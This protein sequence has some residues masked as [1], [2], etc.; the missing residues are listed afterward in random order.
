MKPKLLIVELWGLGDLVIATPFIRAAAEKFD[1]TVL[2]KPYANDLQKVFWPGVTVIPF[3]APWTAFKHKYRL[4]KWPWRELFQVRR[5]IGWNQ[6]D[7]GLSARWDPRDHLLLLLAGVRERFGFPRIGSQLSLTSPVIKAGA[8][9]HRYRAWQILANA[10]GLTLP[11]KS[12][13]PTRSPGSPGEILIHTGAGQSVRV[14]PL[15]RYKR[16]V[17]RLRRCGFAVQVACDPNQIR[18]WRLM[19]ETAALVPHDVPELLHS[20]DR[21]GIFIGND[22]GPGHLAALQ[23]VP[24][25]TLF[26]PQLPQCFAPLHEHAEWIEG[27]ACPHKPCSDYCRYAL[28]HCLWDLSEETVWAR[29]IA[30]VKKHEVMLSTV[31]NSSFSKDEK[32]I[33]RV[34]DSK[35]FI[36]VFNRYL[37]SGGE[38][39]SVARI[40]THLEEAGH[41]VVRFWR[42]SE[43]WEGPESPSALRRAIQLM[44]N[45]AVL[46][47]LREIHQRV[48][49]DAWILHNVIPVISLSIYHLALEL[50]VPIIRWGHNYRP[51]SPSGTMRLRGT[52]LLPDD[53]WLAWKEALAGTWHGRLATAWLALG[54]AWLRFRGDFE[55]VK[56]WIVLSSDMQRTYALAGA[57]RDR[58]YCLSHSWDIRPLIEPGADDGYF[59]FMG[60]MVE[61]KGVKFLLELWNRPELKDVQLVLAGEGP[62]ADEF[63]LKTPKNVRWA[64]FI[65]ADEKRRLIARCRAVLFPALWAEPLGL[66]VFEAYEQGKA[67]IASA[68]GGLTDTITDGRTGKLLDPADDEQWLRAILDCNRNAAATREMGLNG[69]NWLKLNA[70]PTTWNQKFEQILAEVMLQVD[71]TRPVDQTTAGTDDNY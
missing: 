52:S 64:G 66:V 65:R 63:R 28:A 10:L 61:E 53:R 3:T 45:P 21:A 59:L 57:P 2:A 16:L 42:T 38:E 6:F 18:W 37:S 1:V 26:G 50:K 15:E 60:R 55:S 34:G 27:A 23:G 56:A 58:L 29:T 41:E 46:N 36:Q 51:F 20:I 31:S 47:Q 35:R 39:N 12:D 30:F 62:L 4:W 14:W 7:V 22:S 67:V 49:P 24:T 32:S 54:F 43:E 71:S 5:K 48:R 17:A 11:S 9:D 8:L 25:L 70:S 19:G 69:L 13:W 40:A 68:L 33:H 44:K